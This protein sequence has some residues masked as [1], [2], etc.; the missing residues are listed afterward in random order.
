MPTRH[1]FQ[2][3]LQEVHDEILK[4]GT[5]VAEAL[6][7]A[8]TAFSEK[9]I[10]LAERVIAEDGNIDE[11]QLLIEDRCTLIMA[12]QQPVATD[13]RSLITAIK[14]ASSLERIGDHA[15]HLSKTTSRLEGNPQMDP[16]RK[17]IVPMAEEG[18][19]MVKG[20]LTAL[21]DHDTDKAREV[22]AKDN[23]LDRTHARL[24]DTLVNFQKEHPEHALQTTDL[25]FLIRFL[26]RLGDHVTHI[27]EWIIL[28]ETGRYTELNK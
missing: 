28:R 5:L 2:E 17:L 24:F 7:N 25:L 4:M 14:I 9:Q 26:E 10:V 16:L 20:V 13:L 1:H 3:E 12:T 23:S 27:C 21:A 19:S 11:M 6:D 22:A 15:V 18:I 8:L